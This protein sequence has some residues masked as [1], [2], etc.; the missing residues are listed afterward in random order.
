VAGAT[1]AMFSKETGIVVLAVLPLY[2]LLL[3][4]RIDQR[5]MA[6][7]MLPVVPALLFLASRHAAIASTVVP[8][9][10]VDNPIVRAGFWA[11]R[12]T[13]LAVVTRYL[14]LV[15]W[16]AMLSPDYSFPQIPIATGTA[17]EWTAWAVVAGA[18]VL[19]VATLRINR[20]LAFVL[21]AAFLVFLPASNLLF[22]AGTIMAERL[23]YLPSVGVIAA[24]A[25]GASM[26]TSRVRQ[27]TVPVAAASVIL[28]GTLTWLTIERN[29]IWH[30]EVSLWTDAVA[31]SP[32]S[33]KT[34]GALAEA[35]YQSD[36]SRVNLPTVIAHKERSLELLAG[37]PDPSLVL[38]PYREAATYY[39]ERGDWL[40]QHDSADQAGRRAVYEAAA[41][42]AR[43]YSE[44]L[45][46]ARSSASPPNVKQLT[47]AQL[48]LSTT[49]L[50]LSDTAS[51]V[52]AARRGRLANPFAAAAYQAEAAA[53]LD[54]RRT[55]EGA[56]TLLAG[57]M[58][59]GDVSLRARAIDLYRSGLDQGGCAIRNGPTGPVLDQ[60]CDIV[61]RHICAASTEAIAIYDA[62]GRAEL[63]QRTRQSARQ[64]F[65]CTG[66]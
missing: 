48:L 25:A 39:L 55:D 58:V 20:A 51:A 50:R 11:A 22:T 46:T 18:A 28:L 12:L 24:A 60:D 53:M 10:F 14:K 44:V 13:S 5:V 56:V 27:L 61:R 32:R 15:V 35:L 31:A 21:A 54:A 19:T 43:V 6:G 17:S 63:A 16:P 1:I 26:L 42:W 2:D 8:I 7:W 34:H 65:H 38:E 59:T 57:F 47:E 33:F 9:P 62:A 29:Q 41:R 3:G 45:D 37:L 49:A 4:P 30:D 36:P 23:V 40:E 64:E 66:F 52:A